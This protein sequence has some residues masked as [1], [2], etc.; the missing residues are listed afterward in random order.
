MSGGLLVRGFLPY[1]GVMRDRGFAALMAL[2]VALGSAC[3]APPTR[4]L[5]QAQGA[6]E[7]AR[8]AG[9]EEYAPGEFKA[10]ADALRRYDEAVS[11][12]DYRLALSLALDARERAQDAAK[13]AAG[14]KAATRSEAERMLADLT[15]LLTNADERLRRAAARAAAGR[16]DEPTRTIDAARTSVQE[17]RAALAADQ[18]L[19]ARSVLEGVSARLRAA[20]ETL[21]VEIATQGARRRG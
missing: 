11:Q 13:Q 1:T 12:R 6:L 5:H 14:Q 9:A 20:I 18:Y 17:A 7:A 15:A 8:A 21:D 19:Q 10:A 2:T 4:E 3:S 16:L